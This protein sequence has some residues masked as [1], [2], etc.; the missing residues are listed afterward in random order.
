[1]SKF[2]DHLEQKFWS[3]QFCLQNLMKMAFFLATNH[4]NEIVL[5]FLKKCVATRLVMGNNFNDQI[6][7]LLSF[8]SHF[9]LGFHHTSYNANLKKKTFVFVFFT[10][11]ED[12]N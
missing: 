12:E 7:K 9:G 11:H 6:I 2:M 4:Q 8:M 10:H 5:S 3:N 1:M